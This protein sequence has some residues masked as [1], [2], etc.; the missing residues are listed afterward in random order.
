MTRLGRVPQV[1][2]ALRAASELESHDAWDA[3]R[4]AAFQQQRLVAMVRHAADHSPFHRERFAGIELADDL[5]ITALPTLDKALMLEHF[6]DLVT[7][8]RLTLAGIEAHL[9][10]L[11]G[12]HG[13]DDLLLGDYRAMAS[14][15]TT[16]RRGVFVYSRAD[17]T[18]ILGGVLRWLGGDLG[19]T[20][21]LP[22]RMRQA[23][24]VADSPLHM[25]ARMSRSIDI[26]LHHMLR[27]DAR[28]P[29][30]DLVRALN[31]FQPEGLA[32][33]PSVAALLADE[34]LAG[35]LHISPRVVST[36]SE[37]RTADMER[38]IIAAWGTHPFNGYASTE[39]GILAA[40]CDRHTGLH[41]FTD[42]AV[43]EV[44]DDAGRPVVP[45]TPGTRVLV[46]NLVNHT[47]PL[48][49]F[50]LT[51]LVT[52]SPEPCPC[53][54]PFPLLQAIDGRS[55]D[56][57]RM[58]GRDGVPVAVHPLTLRSPLAGI[59]ALRQYRI[60]HDHAGL[61]IEAV[62][63]SDQADAAATIE[64]RLHDALAARGVAPTA[65]TVT[66]V[67]AITRHPGSGKA[68]LIESRV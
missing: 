22:R 16:G 66:P 43:F 59:P 26:G 25:S 12:R 32:T 38:R 33:F 52:V 31:A 55:D 64:H 63:A 51:D 28:T 6:D 20:P 10:D 48:I 68:K 60:V 8:P 19:T 39:T 9:A 14:G 56:V 40:E 2:R 35:R 50:E 13:G 58:P 47:Q 3:D 67:T 49:R 1:V 27:L 7:D 18:P 17:W 37:V 15:G 11:E 23:V 46:T 4:L 21:Q 41:V 57:L 5:D 29:I 62:L 45:G 36:T 44:V 24:V 61:T 30:P 42:Q 34:Q 53:G 65:I 54:R